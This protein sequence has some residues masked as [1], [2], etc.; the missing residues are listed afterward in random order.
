MISAQHPKN[1][2]TIVRNIKRRLS[3]SEARGRLGVFLVYQTT[4]LYT[5]LWDLTI[6]F[7]VWYNQ[8]EVQ[9]LWFM[10]LEASSVIFYFEMYDQHIPMGYN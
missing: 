8:N 9:S 1:T 2:R 7:Y 6:I 4:N 5:C 10:N 3:S